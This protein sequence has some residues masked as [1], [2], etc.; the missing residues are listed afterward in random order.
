MS[1]SKSFVSELSDDMAV[2]T[3]FLAADKSVRETRNG[4]P[5]LCITLQDRTGTI[6]GRGWDNALALDGRFDS[7]DF[8]AVR[9][10]VSSYRGELQITVADVERVDD[11][12]VDLG[13]YLPHSRWDADAMFA[14]LRELVERDVRSDEVRRFLFALFDDDEWRQGFVQAPAAVSNHHAYLAGL[15]E[16]SL[17]MARLAVHLGRHYNAYYP[18]FVDADLLVAGCI[19]H[20]MA[21]AEELQFRRS[22][23]YTTEGRLVGHIARGAE[24]V[25]QVAAGLDPPLDEHLTTQLKHLV[26]SHHGKQEF[27]APVTPKSPE[28]ILLHQ[29]DMIDSRMNMGWNACKELLEG[30][31]PTEDWSDYQRNFGRFLYVGGEAARGWQCAPRSEG[32]EQGPGIAP[33]AAHASSDESD[34]SAATEEIDESPSVSAEPNLELFEE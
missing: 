2:E 26:L 16:H 4:D 32:L 11:D 34:D 30:E 22:F 28:A 27:G 5:Y 13:D 19:I 17:S 8:I 23:D 9:G 10:R 12:S 18:G 21:K 1:K 3:V 33:P 31:N 14:A 25:G 15:L 6:E 20:D 24:L 29:I 7:D